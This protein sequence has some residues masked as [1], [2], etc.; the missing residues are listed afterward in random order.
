EK[1]GLRFARKLLPQMCDRARNEGI[2][3][4]LLVGLF[5]I[6]CSGFAFRHMDRLDGF[7]LRIEQDE[8]AIP[9]AFER[10]I[11]VPDVRHI[12][13]ERGEQERAKLAFSLVRLRVAFGLQKRC[14]KSLYHVLGIAWRITTPPG[15]AVSRRPVIG[16]E[17]F[18]GC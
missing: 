14:E 1:T 13:L 5:L 12:V 18:E 17:L 15:E 16:T 2:R 10:M 3:P 4:A 7:H 11:A 8:P 9:A 6:Q